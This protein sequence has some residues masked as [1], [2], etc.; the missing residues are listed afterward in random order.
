[1]KQEFLNFVETLIEENP[2]KAKELMTDNIIAYLNILKDSK[3][4]KPIL[5]KNGAPLLKF[6]Q[7]HQDIKMWKARDIAEGLGRSSRGISGTMRKL[8]NDGFCESV[9]KDPV[10]YTL[11]EKGKNYKIEEIDND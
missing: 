9:G 1:M 7:E 8:V 5:T 4:E 6:L 2:E 11:T 10:I 3:D